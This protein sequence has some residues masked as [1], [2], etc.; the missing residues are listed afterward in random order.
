MEGT[1]SSHMEGGAAVVRLQPGK[2]ECKGKGKG[3]D[4]ATRLRWL[5]RQYSWYKSQQSE[6]EAKQWLGRQAG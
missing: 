6:S 2:G 5:R 4:R 3:K 1:F